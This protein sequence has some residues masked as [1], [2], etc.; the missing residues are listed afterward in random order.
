MGITD[1]CSILMYILQ[2]LIL[3]L[4]SDVINASPGH[5]LDRAWNAHHI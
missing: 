5:G 1:F 2:L 4:E 3:I